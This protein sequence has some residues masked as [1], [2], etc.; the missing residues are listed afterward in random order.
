MVALRWHPEATIVTFIARG[1]C[2]RISV[3]KDELQT[4]SCE[5]ILLLQERIFVKIFVIYETFYE[6]HAE[7]VKGQK[8]RLKLSD[9]L[10]L[11]VYRF[12]FKY[13]FCCSQFNAYMSDKY[14]VLLRLLNILISSI[15]NFHLYLSF[16]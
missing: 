16:I 3:V 5:W 13:Q 2:V 4:M 9:S 7:L 12:I 11:P 8:K 15:Y 1:R 14:Y 6:N 10:F